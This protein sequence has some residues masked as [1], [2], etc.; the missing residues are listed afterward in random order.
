MSARELHILLFDKTIATAIPAFARTWVTA[1]AVQ[2]HALLL[3][4]KMF[5]VRIVR[6]TLVINNPKPELTYLAWASMLALGKPA[7]AREKAAASGIQQSGVSHFLPSGETKG[8]MPGS[9]II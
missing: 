3:A 7:I 1:W 2:P 9:L 8:N 6:V 5:M 4:P